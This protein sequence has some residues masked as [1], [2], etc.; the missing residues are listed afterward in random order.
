M[1]CHFALYIVKYPG[2]ILL[3]INKEIQ[4]EYDDTLVIAKLQKV[5]KPIIIKD[6]KKEYSED[7]SVEYSFDDKTIKRE[8]N[9]FHIAVCEKWDELAL[10]EDRNYSELEFKYSCDSHDVDERRK[11]IIQIVTYFIDYYRKATGDATIEN[12]FEINSKNILVHEYTRKYQ[13]GEESFTEAE[14]LNSILSFGMVRKD[15]N[16]LTYGSFNNNF[17][18][19]HIDKEKNLNELKEIFSKPDNELFDTDLLLKAYQIHLL[20]K[21]YKYS[22]LDAFIFLEQL[23][24]RFTNNKLK[25]ANVSK[26]K[27]DKHEKDIGISY[28]I[29]VILPLFLGENEQKDKEVLNKLSKLNSKR[30]NVVHKAEK[31][32]EEES[33]QIIELGYKMMEIIK[34]YAD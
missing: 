13:S 8:S 25:E 30:N 23:V 14:R 22:F 34:K 2:E 11:N 32:S 21:T 10:I 1:R 4:F 12:D 26:S 24:V 5:F 6:F 9:G 7:L 20:N 33:F 31:V 19:D 18:H 16:F 3:P 17:N 29:D 27:I 15:L 28:L